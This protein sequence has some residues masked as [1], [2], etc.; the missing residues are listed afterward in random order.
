MG[1]KITIAVDPR[2]EG[3]VRR[4]LAL[5]EEMEQL[6]LTAPEG[7]VFATCEE[8]VIAKGRKLQS[9][10][11]GEA[12]TRP[13]R[14]SKK[15]APLRVCACGRPQENRGPKGRFPVSAVGAVALTRRYWKCPCGADG[16]YAADAVLGVE[17]ERYTQAVHKH[18]CRLAADMSF[19]STSENLHAMLGADVCP[20]T[21]RT[22]VAG[23]GQKM[24]RASK[25]RIRPAKTP[26]AGRKARSNLRPLRARSTP[27]KEAGKTWKSRSSPSARQA[28]RLRRRSGSRSGCRWRRSCRPS[29]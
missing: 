6:A 7:R 3:I 17:G 26:S 9:A 18:G 21:V 22:V 2:H 13:S 15:G 16:S 19:A 20:E 5:A 12:V 25:A 29:R 1:S 4:V 23:P 27:G 10:V 14:P 11:L 8:A 28:N 24:A